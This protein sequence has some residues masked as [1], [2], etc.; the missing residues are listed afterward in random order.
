MVEVELE[1][2]Q[3]KVLFNEKCVFCNG[4]SRRHVQFTFS[5]EANSPNAELVSFFLCRGKACSYLS[6]ITICYI[7]MV[8]VKSSDSLE[9]NKQY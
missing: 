9:G 1:N 2:A 8:F 6:T 3:L 5:A 4:S 7:Y